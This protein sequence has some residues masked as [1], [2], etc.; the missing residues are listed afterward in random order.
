[1]K[2]R[3]ATFSPKP[4]NVARYHAARQTVI[5]WPNIELEGVVAE[6]AE[7][8]DKPDGKKEVFAELDNVE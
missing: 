3:A 4:T 8:E 7:P 1:M 2:A 5:D 6:V